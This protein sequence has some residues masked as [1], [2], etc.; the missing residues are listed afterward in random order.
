MARISNSTMQKVTKQLSIPQEEEEEI[1]MAIGQFAEA[2]QKGDA[3]KTEKA[4]KELEKVAK[5]ARIKMKDVE[6]ALAKAGVK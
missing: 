3:K 6:K 1:M 5:K 4:Q 2:K